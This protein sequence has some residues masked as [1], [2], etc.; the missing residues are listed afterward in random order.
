VRP[1]QKA[2]RSESG[3]ED[4]DALNV[5]HWRER[6]I[7]IAWSHV[8]GVKGDLLVLSKAILGAAVEGYLAG[9]ERDL[10]EVSGEMSRVPSK[11]P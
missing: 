7:W 2:N 4:H 3:L 9:L 8:G 11:A 6:R 5:P 10:A 1:I